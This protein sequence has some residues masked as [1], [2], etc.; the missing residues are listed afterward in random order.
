MLRAEPFRNN[1]CSFLGASGE[2]SR[3]I[4]HYIRNITF[5]LRV[6]TFKHID[7]LLKQRYKRVI[8]IIR[9]TY[10]SRNVIIKYN[11]KASYQCLCNGT[12]SSLLKRITRRHKHTNNY[13]LNVLDVD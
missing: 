10:L 8:D 3:P 6:T 11:W 4:V 9:Y 1:F 5:L 7:S 12:R 13:A 2:H